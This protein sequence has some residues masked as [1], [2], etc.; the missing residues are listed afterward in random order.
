MLTVANSPRMLI[1][2]VPHIKHQC[3]FYKAVWL[4]GRKEERSGLVRDP[5]I[6]DRLPS[7]ANNST[8]YTNLSTGIKMAAVA[9]PGL[10][11]GPK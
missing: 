5:K 6:Y 8:K 11:Y 3:G 10:L 4:K 1:S 2:I 9:H 7:L